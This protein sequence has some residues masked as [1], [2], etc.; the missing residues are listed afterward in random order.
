MR[1]LICAI[2]MMLLA[3]AVAAKDAAPIPVQQIAKSPPQ[4]FRHFLIMGQVDSCSGSSCHL[5]PA[6]MTRENLEWDQCLS[7]SF[8]GF[9]SSTRHV[10][11][12]SSLMDR[13]FR[14]AT[15]VMEA[16]YDPACARQGMCLDRASVIVNARVVQVLSRKTARNG[17][18]YA[19]WGRLV[20][21]GEADRAEMNKLISTGR[22]TAF[23]IKLFRVQDEEGV[24]PT[25]LACFCTKTDCTQ[26]WPEHYFAGFESPA[27]PFFCTL[28]EKRAEGWR[29]F[30]NN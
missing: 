11:D 1:N 27:N 14:F 22:P 9:S 10:G 4:D 5:C 2:A 6:D 16:D 17:L 19:N 3:P 20:E 24:D 7:L 28:M 30:T 23:G 26:D 18:R 12:V 15:V 25:G 29:I 21:P 13:A 8:D